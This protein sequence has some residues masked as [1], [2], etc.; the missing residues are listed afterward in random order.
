MDRIRE[1]LTFAT[2][3]TTSVTENSPLRTPA[4]YTGFMDRAFGQLY[5]H[6][7]CHSTPGPRVEDDTPSINSSTLSSSSCTSFQPAEDLYLSFQADGSSESQ[8][9]NATLQTARVDNVPQG[10]ASSSTI[11]AGNHQKTR[12]SFLKDKYKALRQLVSQV[13]Q[14]R[15]PS[16]TLSS[17]ANVGGLLLQPCSMS[18]IWG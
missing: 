3:Q 4:D 13:K 7:V 6:P 14:T 2:D 10:Y 1:H 15:L 5:V 12:I 17:N 11:A 16:N 8:L 9:V 18:Q